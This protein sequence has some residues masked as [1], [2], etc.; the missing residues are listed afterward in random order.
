M[1]KQVCILYSVLQLI[2]IY[3]LFVKPGLQLQ[4]P[5]VQLMALRIMYAKPASYEFQT[6]IISCICCFTDQ[7]ISYFQTLIMR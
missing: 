1:L 5:H 6:Y 7:T 4:M 3:V 2:C